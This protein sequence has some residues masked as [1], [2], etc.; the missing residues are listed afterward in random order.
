MQR[1][2]VN[3][4]LAVGA[5]FCMLAAPRAMMAQQ[6]PIETTANVQPTPLKTTALIQP[7]GVPV[8]TGPNGEGLLPNAIGWNKIQKKTGIVAEYYLQV[9]VSTNNNIQK[10]D[11]STGNAAYPGDGNGAVATPSD[12]DTLTLEQIEQ[13]LHRNDKSNIVSGITPTP[14]PMYKHFD[15]GFLSDT[16]YGRSPKG[17]LMTGFDA[18]WAM[19]P[20]PTNDSANRYMYLCEPNAFVTLYFPVF[21]GLS[22]QFGRMDDLIA[23]DEVPP[24]A[25]WSPNIFYSKSYGFYRDMTVVG[26]RIDANIFHNQKY[27]Y[28]MGEFGV[29]NGNK[30]AHSLNG[31]LNYVYGLRYASPKMGTEIAYTGRVGMGNIKTNADCSITA[32]TMQVKPVWASDAQANYHVYSPKAQ[33]SFENGLKVVQKV[34]PHLKVTALM[35]FGKQFGDGKASTIAVYSPAVVSSTSYALDL[36]ICNIAHPD[37]TPYCRAGFTG[38]S[39]L[40]YEGMATYTIK[41][42]KLTASVRLEQ[43]RNPNGYFGQPVFSVVSNTYNTDAYKGN[44]PNWGGAKGAFNETTLGVN[45][46]PAR[47]LRLRPEIRYDWQSG[48]YVN[49]A[50]GRSNPNG[51]TSSSQVTAGIDAIISF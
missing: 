35:Q 27:G 20:S 43:F 32:C 33:R 38:A 9:G 1:I 40:S 48:N 8:P 18:N 3:A 49:N 2:T 15:W 47:A 14:A 45:Y 25:Q 42:N 24:A 50:F 46:N 29:N 5:C 17:C 11:P 16:V 36:A 41:P 28:L 30:T 19:N 10:G 44:P 51:K 34:N 39:Y 7:A 13:F 37:Q 26:S 23:I 4:M 21:K 22:L 12:A 6:S 31:N